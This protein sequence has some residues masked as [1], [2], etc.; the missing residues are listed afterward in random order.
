MKR[1]RREIILAAILVLIYASM[2][3]TQPQKD[4]ESLVTP[5]TVTDNHKIRLRS[6][7]V[8]LTVSV[9]DRFDR[10]ITGLTKEQ[11]EVYDDKVKQEIEHF[12]DVDRPVSIAIV[13][14]VSDSMEERLVR[15]FRA[16][17]KFIGT[18]HGD[19]DFC[20]IAFNNKVRLVRDFTT[21]NSEILA[22][23]TFVK[24]K[25]WTALYDAAYLAAEKLEHGRHQKKAMLIISDG[26][27]N[28]SRYTYK[29]LRNR[30]KESDVQIYALGITDPVGDVN[31][32]VGRGILE[33]IA[34]MTGGRA[35]FP[36]ADKETELVEAC[37][38]IALE[39][40]HQ[41]S[42]GFYP[43]DP[44]R[45]DSHKVRIKVNVK[46]RGLGRLS[47]NYKDKY[48]SFRSRSEEVGK[49]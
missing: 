28:G 24:S 40:R 10:L 23:L 31:A 30:L 19:D 21:S 11:F 6:R 17:D 4:A 18:S 1:I 38:R 49:K 44:D 15:A 41:Y 20:L 16:L 5:A 29:E 12:T 48:P 33:E 14:D 45:G 22:S 26:Q 43:T 9:T 13:Y 2:A 35:F 34:R 37:A 39:L 47:L 7:L 32:G 3:L 46:G 42:I 8:S 27:D 36:N 25:G